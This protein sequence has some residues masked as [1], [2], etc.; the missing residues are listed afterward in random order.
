[1]NQC[2]F[3][4]AYYWAKALAKQTE[5]T[6]LQSIFIQVA[7]HISNSEDKIV[8]ELIDIQGKSVDIGGYYQPDEELT[9]KSMRPNKTLNSILDQI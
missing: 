7:N 6:E 5:D 8:S 4:L 9:S 1:M 2:H 3:Y